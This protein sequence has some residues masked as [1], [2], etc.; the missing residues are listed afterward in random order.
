VNPGG[1]I[2]PP[3]C[4]GCQSNRHAMCH[5]FISYFTDFG[6]PWCGAHNFGYTPRCALDS[7]R[8]MRGPDVYDSDCINCGSG[9]PAL[10]AALLA[11]PSGYEGAT[12]TASTAADATSK[13]RTGGTSCQPSSVDHAGEVGLPASGRQTH[14]VGHLSANLVAGSLLCLHRPRRSKLVQHHGRRICCLDCQQHLGSCPSPSWLQ[15]HHRQ[16]IFQA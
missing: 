4:R 11:S 14:P 15:R 2:P 10:P 5:A 7:T 12:G 13:G 3:P 9:I 8:T 6:C 16:M 1:Q